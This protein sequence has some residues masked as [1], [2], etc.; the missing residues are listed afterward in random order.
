MSSLLNVSSLNGSI[1]IHVKQVEGFVSNLEKVLATQ[2]HL[3]SKN[4]WRKKTWA[5]SD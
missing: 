3:L 5:L 4:L 2:T 1:A